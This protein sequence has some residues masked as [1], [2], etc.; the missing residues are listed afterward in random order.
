MTKRLKCSYP[1]LTCKP[2]SVHA[3]CPAPMTISL[4]CELPH[5]SCGLPE[6]MNLAILIAGSYLPEGLP[7]LDLAPCGGYLAVDIT[8][9][10]GGLLHHHFTL[11]S[12]RLVALR[13]IS[14]ALSGRLPRPG[15]CPAHCPLECGL[16]SIVFLPR[17]SGRPGYSHHTIIYLWRTVGESL[18]ACKTK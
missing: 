5:T 4:G 8:A 9:H 6:V 2:H 16:S 14:V 13:Y 3:G 12:H 11:T 7:L 1:R 18:A 15:N 10:A 17:S